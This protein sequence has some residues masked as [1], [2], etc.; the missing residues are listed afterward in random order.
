M[1]KTWTNQQPFAITLYVR[2]A[3]ASSSAVPARLQQIISDAIVGSPVFVLT[4]DGAFHISPE[5]FGCRT[6]PVTGGL[7]VG[8]WTFLAATLS[9]REGLCRVFINGR[10]ESTGELSGIYAHQWTSGNISIGSGFRGDIDE[11]RIHNRTLTEADAAHLYS[12]FNA[13]VNQEWRRTSGDVPALQ[14]ARD[15]K[16]H[17]VHV[18]SQ[19]WTAVVNTNRLRIAEGIPP[20]SS[21]RASVRTHVVMV[22]SEIVTRKVDETSRQVLRVMSTSHDNVEDAVRVYDARAI[23]V[24][25]TVMVA[26]ALLFLEVNERYVCNPFAEFSRLMT[27]VAMLKVDMLPDTRYHFAELRTMHAAAA[28][29]LANLREYKTFLPASIV[30]TRDSQGSDSAGV[31]LTARSPPGVGDEDPQVA[32]VFTD[33][34]A[35]TMLWETVPNSMPEAMRTHNR[36]IR[37]CIDKANGYEVKTI[38]DS[39]MVAFDNSVDA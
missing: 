4:G 12:D 11:L 1:L 6:D 27:D 14:V 29:M 34:K 13:R 8:E 2:P 16:L 15:L 9:P 20:L 30:S 7:P 39:F 17:D 32:I 38:G 3:P 19:Q 23:L 26:F 18:A 33:V 36:V 21:L 35:S 28:N 10:L 5:Q 37:Q 31:T 24:M 25:T 22:P